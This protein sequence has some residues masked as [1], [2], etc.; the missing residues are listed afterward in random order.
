MLKFAPSM[1]KIDE[2]NGNKKELQRAMKEE[3]AKTTPKSE[4]ATLPGIEFS[5]GA[6]LG[7]YSRVGACIESR[8][9][10]EWR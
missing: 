6:H 3:V 1:D 8:V 7:V 2:E 10:A 5:F 4:I 9:L